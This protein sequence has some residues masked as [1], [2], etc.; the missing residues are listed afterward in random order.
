MNRWYK[1]LDMRRRFFVERFDGATATLHGESAAHLTRVLRAQ[2]DQ[3]YELSDGE[4]VWVARVERAGRGSVEFTLIEPITARESSLQ[5]QLLLA[6]VKFDRFE[7]CLEKAT[8]LGA[9]EIVPL[10]AERSGK[11]LLAAA[12]KRARRWEKILLESAQQ[13]RRFRVP[14]LAALG[15][16]QAAFATSQA[17]VKILLSERRE[18]PP[19][20]EFLAEL[21]PIG[22]RVQHA[23][24]LQSPGRAEPPSAGKAPLEAEPR[25]AMLQHRSGLRGLFGPEDVPAER[26]LVAPIES[27]RSSL[28][29]PEPHS[30][31]WS[32][33][34]EGQGLDPSQERFGTVEGS[35]KWRR[36]AERVSASKADASAIAANA[37][38][39]DAAPSEAPAAPE[40][41]SHAVAR[42]ALAIGP[43][44]GW[45]EDELALARSAG[46][47]EASLGANILRTET[48]VIAA[49]AVLNYAL[50][51]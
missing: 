29:E 19:L 11:A 32:T 39:E 31:V 41:V 33:L 46:F 3:L 16:P 12:A 20:R 27:E 2:R 1:I 21:G 26:S 44:G 18:A 42:V 48:A 24:P 34:A 37:A 45:T 28:A 25:G 8:E 50:G 5:I 36:I 7:W 17:D 23:A 15:R 4:K 30:S 49:L 35:A 10:A 13:A 6:I 47:H 9:T 38:T 40:V 22:K 43:E 51:D 14:S